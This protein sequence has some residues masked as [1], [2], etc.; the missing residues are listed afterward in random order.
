MLSP[1]IKF[2]KGDLW[3]IKKR[4]YADRYCSLDLIEITELFTSGAMKCSTVW[5]DSDQPQYLHLPKPPRQSRVY[6]KSEL[7]WHFKKITKDEARELGFDIP[8]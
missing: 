3:L 7:A 8:Q 2:E 6:L 5:I 1:A 4:L